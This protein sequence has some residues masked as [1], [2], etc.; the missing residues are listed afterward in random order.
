MGLIIL[1]WQA[2]Y[3][4]LF[5]AALIAA[6]NAIHLND[7][8]LPEGNQFLSVDNSVGDQTTTAS[9]SAQQVEGNKAEI[10]EPMS[11]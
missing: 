2:F 6:S 8:I 3:R 1:W 5:V 11:L 4:L 7:E 10:D 9:Q